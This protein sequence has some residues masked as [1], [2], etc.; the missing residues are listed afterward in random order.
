MKQNREITRPELCER[1]NVSLATVR[2]TIAQLKELK[3]LDRIGSDKSGHWVVTE[4][5]KGGKS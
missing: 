2:I 5:V 3:L 1:L 4:K